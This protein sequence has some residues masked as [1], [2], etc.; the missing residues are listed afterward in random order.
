[1]R[2]AVLVA[3]CVLAAC[4]SHSPRHAGGQREPASQPAALAPAG[5]PN[6]ADEV[7]ESICLRLEHCVSRRRTIS[8][9]DC[10]AALARDSEAQLRSCWTCLEAVKE[11]CPPDDVCEHACPAHGF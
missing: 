7:R 11:D 4:S 3:S 10:R 8:V 6:A 2:R 9:R 5:E 1:V